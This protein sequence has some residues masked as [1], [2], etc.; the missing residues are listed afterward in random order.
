MWIVTKAERSALSLTRMGTSLSLL[1]TAVYITRSRLEKLARAICWSARSHGQRTELRNNARML[2]MLSV[3]K[4]LRPDSGASPNFSSLARKYK[5]RDTSFR[6][7]VT[8]REGCARLSVDSSKRHAP[9]GDAAVAAADDDD[10]AMDVLSTI[11]N[12]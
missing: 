11:P 2:V 5:T 7:L 6:F 10:E 1:R 9:F 4:T 12:S 3:R 8:S